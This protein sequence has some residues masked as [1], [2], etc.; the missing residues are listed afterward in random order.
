MKTEDP[1]SYNE[2]PVQ[3]N[4]YINA[5]FPKRLKKQNNN[6]TVLVDTD[7]APFQ[8]RNYGGLNAPISDSS[9]SA[10]LLPEVRL[11]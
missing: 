3:S 5:H 7:S 4:K 9:W 6:N 2:D 1:E 8:D 10:A 11:P